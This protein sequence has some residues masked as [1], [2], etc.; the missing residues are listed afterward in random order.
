[1]P[2][3]EER[4]ATLESG[5]GALTADFKALWEQVNS[6]PHVPWDQS[7]R[8]RLHRVSETLAAADK[9]AEAAREMR[10]AR[11]HTFSVAERILLAVCAVA[12][13]VSPYVIAFWPS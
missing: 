12:A 7:V 8:G 3:A 6:G 1:M 2:T 10:R 4:L 9:L 11:R 13:A 5:L